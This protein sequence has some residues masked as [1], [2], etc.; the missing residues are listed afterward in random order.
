[1]LP[2]MDD[3]EELRDPDLWRRALFF[4]DG[5]EQFLLATGVHRVEAVHR[6]VGLLHIRSPGHYP[7]SFI[8]GEVLD[9]EFRLVL[10][11]TEARFHVKRRRVCHSANVV[12]D[13]MPQENDRLGGG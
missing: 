4:V 13:A 10:W 1:M 8:L 6:V 2:G 11:E 7:L 3:A 12:G 5:L 9:E